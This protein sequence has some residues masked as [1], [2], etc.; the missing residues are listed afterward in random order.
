MSN[1]LAPHRSAGLAIFNDRKIMTKIF[2]GFGILLAILALTSVMAYRAFMTLGENVRNYAEDVGIVRVSRDVDN[3]FTRLNKAVRE[4]ALTGEEANLPEVEAAKKE[5]ADKLKTAA[6]TINDAEDLTNLR[7]TQKTIATFESKIDHLI[8]ANRNHRV[9]LTDKLD[10]TGDQLAKIAEQLQAASATKYG[11]SEAATLIADVQKYATLARLNVNKTLGRHDEASLNEAEK[12]FSDLNT[13]LNAITAKKPGDDLTPHISQTM[14]LA[15]SFIETARKAM[16]DQ[17]AKT[18]LINGE[19]ADLASEADRATDEIVKSG[20]E[21]QERTE[22]NALNV[23]ESAEQMSLYAGILGMLLGASL[24][25]IIGRMISKPIVGITAAMN[26]LAAGDLDVEIPGQGNRDEIGDMAKATSVFRDA[27]IENK[28][29]QEEAEAQRQKQKAQEEA[30]RLAE[31]EAQRKSEADRIVAEEDRRRA[32][33]EAI[34]RERDIVSSSIGAA[35][36]KLAQRDLTY[37]ITQDIPEAYSKLKD[38]F[39]IA[40]AELEAAIDGVA[41]RASSIATGTREIASGSDE[42]ARRTETQAAALEE[43]AAALASITE[44]MQGAAKATDHARSVVTIAKKDAEK[45]SEIVKSTVAAMANI[46]KSSQQIGQIIGVIDEI[47]FQTN[48]L[49]LNAGVEAARAGDAGRGFAVVASEVRALAQRSAEAAKEIKGLITASGAQ[50][51]EG[52]ELV[53]QTG[54]SLE[55]ILS[56]ISEINAVV[57]TIAAGA[58]EQATGIEQVNQAISQMDQN[59]QKNASMAEET[60]AAGQT[61]AT[62]AGHLSEV[63]LQ[64]K[65][66]SSAART[67]DVTSRQVQALRN[68]ART[69]SAASKTFTGP[70]A[71]VVNG[72]GWEEF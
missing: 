66:S 36:T 19:M 12:S 18:A 60:N 52:V 37:R 45:S 61:L 49:A 22:R 42:L 6:S 9:L 24:A 55:R 8:S 30:Q 15:G 2:S 11:L 16:S 32:E 50:V 31:A 14:A 54:Q 34:Q 13:T 28:R 67:T 23:V 43:S 53:D 27:A 35:I 62:D 39:N 33:A 71:K 7:E 48:L 68:V 1:T 10:P 57:G 47:A 20:V 41:T 56:Q 59:T 44:T 63:V 72:D 69:S 3:A 64:F 58:A 70:I 25:W 29:L 40:I 65:I 5:L 46:E 51:V 38:D 26:K 17:K 4:Y 21:D